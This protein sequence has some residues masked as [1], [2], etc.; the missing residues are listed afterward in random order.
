M[1]RDNCPL[2]AS[3]A[4]T[5][6]DRSADCLVDVDTVQTPLASVRADPRKIKPDAETGSRATAHEWPSPFLK[7]VAGEIASRP[8]PVFAPGLAFAIFIVARL[9]YSLIGPLSLGPLIR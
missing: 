9:S 4:T 7:M 1:L 5:R 3:S 6:L 2:P 8:C